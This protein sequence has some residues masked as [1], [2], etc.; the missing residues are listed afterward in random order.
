M[1]KPASRHGSYN[2]RTLLVVVAVIC[3]AVGSYVVGSRLQ[4]AEQEVRQRRSETGELTIEDRSKV[5]IVAVE[6]DEPNTW[7]WRMYLPKGARYQWNIAIDEIPRYSPPRRAAMSGVSN[8]R[9]WE[10]ENEVFI[11]AK[12]R[13]GDEGAWQ[14]SV[15]SRIGNSKNQ[16]G[17]AALT[18]PADKL[19]WL[20]SVPCTDG[21]VAGSNDTLVKE[22]ND[23]VIL[24]QKRPSEQKSDGSFEP[25]PDPMPGFMVWLQ[26]W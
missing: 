18:I 9:Y 10:Q 22:P 11:T 4:E 17:G 21:Q 7:H 23:S 15:R 5:H 6:A 12:L 14:L 1:S 13:K 19:A 3:F 8:E 25:S 16:M 2:L 24:L 26:K 20:E